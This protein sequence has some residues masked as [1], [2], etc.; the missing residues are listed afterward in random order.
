V[1]SRT[2]RTGFLCWRCT[3]PAAECAGAGRCPRCFSLTPLPAGAACCATCTLFPLPYTS[4]R[5]LWEYGGLP[6]DLIR[7]LKYRPSLVLTR[8][9]GAL[10][11]EAARGWG[12]ESCAWEVL[13]PIPPSPLSASRRLFSPC[14]ELAHQVRRALP[15]ASVCD[16]LRHRRRRSPQAHRSHAERLIGI[17]TLF[18]VRDPLRIAGRSV[19]LVED[20]VTTGA[21]VAAAADALLRAGATRVDLI[22]LARTRVWGRFRG[23][24]HKLFTTSGA[25][26]LAPLTGDAARD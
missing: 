22:T 3:P 26:H 1:C 14:L 17:T 25:A 20:V 16:V 2:L 11:A 13:V 12:G 23:S 8:H 24:V 18:T 6:R 21:T 15:D 7:A 19:V 9:A 5:Y 10:L 4:V